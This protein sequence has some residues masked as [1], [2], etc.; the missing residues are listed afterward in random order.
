MIDISIK[1]ILTRCHHT[2]LS[3]CFLYWKCTFYQKWRHRFGT[4][5]GPWY[6]PIILP[7]LV[8]HADQSHRTLHLPYIVYMYESMNTHLHFNLQL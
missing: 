7:Q 2:V 5:S 8:E 1:Y 3:F 6:C 4:W